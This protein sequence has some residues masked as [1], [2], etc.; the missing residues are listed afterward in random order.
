MKSTS[1][2]KVYLASLATASVLYRPE[3]PSSRRNWVFS[4]FQSA[5]RKVGN[6]IICRGRPTLLEDEDEEY[7]TELLKPHSSM[8]GAILLNSI[9]TAPLF[10][11]AYK[12]FK[13][14]YS[15]NQNVVGVLAMTEGMQQFTEWLLEDKANDPA[16]KFPPFILIFNEKDHST[17][18]NK[19]RSF[20]QSSL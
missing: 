18:L 7:I 4:G 8:A 13:D 17:Q 9:K 16:Q 2:N 1:S 12:L 14:A 6:K 11:A 5:N 20:V 10:K 15:N 3:K 19:D